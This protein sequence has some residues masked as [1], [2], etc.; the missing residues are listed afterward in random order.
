ML[1]GPIVG[2]TCSFAP[3][4]NPSD[5]GKADVDTSKAVSLT[6]DNHVFVDD[7]NASTPKIA[8]KGNFQLKRVFT[9]IRMTLL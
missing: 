8:L 3:A 6:Y 1:Q 7:I 5:T 2:Y 9:E 4:V